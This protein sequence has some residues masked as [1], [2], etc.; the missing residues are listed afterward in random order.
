MGQ[1]AKQKWWQN[2]VHLGAAIEVVILVLE[3]IADCRFQLT[4]SVPCTDRQGYE[5]LFQRWHP[6]LKFPPRSPPLSLLLW[7]LLRTDLMGWNGPILMDLRMFYTSWVPAF[8]TYPTGM[9]KSVW[10]YQ[11]NYHW[12]EFLKQY[13]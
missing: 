13:I 12:N 1:S 8:R 6:A 7:G 4:L 5:G 9:C 2:G 3:V 11:R 10:V